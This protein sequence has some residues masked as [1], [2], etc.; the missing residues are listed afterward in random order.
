MPKGTAVGAARYNQPI[1]AG[2]TVPQGD[3][4]VVT[5]LFV[6]GPDG[7]PRWA[8]MGLCRNANGSTKVEIAYYAG[9]WNTTNNVTSVKFKSSIAGGI[10]ASSRIIFFKGAG[11]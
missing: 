1:I 8:N 9:A 11:W 2:G 6:R 5:L 4:G 10:G 7:H 3:G